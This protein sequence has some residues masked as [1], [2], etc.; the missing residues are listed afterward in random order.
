MATFLF[1]KIIFGPVKSRRLGVSLGVNLLPTNKKFCNFDCLYCECG[2]SNNSA[3]TIENLPSREL[4]KE[5]LE[6]KIR[7]M[8]EEDIVPDVITF[9]GNGEPTIHPDFLGIIEDTIEI[10]D[11]LCPEARIAVLSNSTTLHKTH[12]VKALKKVDQSILKLDTAIEETYQFVNRPSSGTTISKI[13][14]QLKNYGDRLILQTLFLKGSY[15]GVNIDNS[16]NN[17]L[18]K[19]LAA[20]KKI[21]PESI[22]IYT[23]ERDTPLDSL[24]KIS[25]KKL[26]EIARKIKQLGIPVEISG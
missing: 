2:W 21:Q 10:R 11:K 5:E 20:Y 13:I 6:K 18:E 1:D 7:S 25:I 15:K 17:E 3:V 14:D 8:S 24:E 12:V 23:F 16:S 4:C 22:M 19:L 9:A 26:N